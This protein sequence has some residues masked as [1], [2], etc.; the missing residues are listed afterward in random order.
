MA[1]WH[2]PCPNFQP[3]H[4]KSRSSLSEAL[5]TSTHREQCFQCL[6]PPQRL[7][8][9]CL[10][11]QKQCLPPPNS[12]CTTR[13]VHRHCAKHN[14]LGAAG[15]GA[16]A[17][18]TGTAGCRVLA[19]GDWQQ[20]QVQSNSKQGHECQRGGTRRGRVEGGPR[21]TLLRWGQGEGGGKGVPQ[22]RHRQVL[23]GECVSEWV[24]GPGADAPS[25]EESEELAIALAVA[26]SDTKGRG[27]QGP[28]RAPHCVLDTVLCYCHR[29]FPT[30]NGCPC[31]ENER[32]G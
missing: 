30:T 32:P 18:P 11:S 1:A 15:T 24:R 17:V 4:T 6:S 14:A 29:L 27:H 13:G 16:A 23:W 21:G 22:G 20:F 7:P 3:G 28:G 2:L 10:C 25:E 19:P 5:P 12:P 8:C 26:A 9:L 31:Q